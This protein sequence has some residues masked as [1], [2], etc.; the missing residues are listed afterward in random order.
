LINKRIDYFQSPLGL[1]KITVKH[2][3]LI[4]IKYC[5]ENE[6]IKIDNDNISIINEIKTQL[7]EYFN[8]ERRE[9][10][11]SLKIEGTQFQKDVYKTL[12]KVGYGEV[13]TYKN[14]AER[15]GHP[16]AYRAV[17]TALKNNK[18][19][20]IIPCHRVIK[21]DNSIGNYNGGVWRKE[22]LLQLEDSNFF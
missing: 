3:K 20:I 16:K 13:I 4:S 2:D 22:K 11:L 21:T 17:G 5:K 12:Q 7:R 14:L 6:K 8:K 1:L 15:S 10:N 19:P 18:I 9:F